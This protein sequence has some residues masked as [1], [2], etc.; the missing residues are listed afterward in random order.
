MIKVV[1]V[2]SE[3]ERH[4]SRGIED[5]AQIH[6][7][8]N[9]EELA[10]MRSLYMTGTELRAPGMAPALLSKVFQ[11]AKLDSNRGRFGVCDRVVLEFSDDI[12][13]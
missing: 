2:I 6:P 4:P 13:D 8:M 5:M 1:S 11:I 9:R 12:A 3:I 10:R 7:R